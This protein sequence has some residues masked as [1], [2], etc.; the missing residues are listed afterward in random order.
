V[1]GAAAQHLH[2]RQ[3]QYHYNQKRRQADV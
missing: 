3:A 2:A 1:K